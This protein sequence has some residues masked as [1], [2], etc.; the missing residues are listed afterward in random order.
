MERVYSHNPGT[1]ME[2]LCIQYLLYFSDFSSQ[3]TSIG[4]SAH[5]VK[6]TVQQM[7]NNLGKTAGP[8]VL[9]HEA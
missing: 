4:H 9:F 5:K 3:F 1:H 8:K 2:P 6:T 7:T